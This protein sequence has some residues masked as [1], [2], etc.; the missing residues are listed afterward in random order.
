MKN[1]QSTKPNALAWTLIRLQHQNDGMTQ[2]VP[3]WNPFCKHDS[4]Q[5]HFEFCLLFPIP[6]SWY[7]SDPS[8]LSLQPSSHLN[9]SHNL[10]VFSLTAK[11]DGDLN[12][13]SIFSFLCTN[14]LCQIR[15]ENR[16]LQKVHSC[17]TWFSDKSYQCLNNL[18]VSSYITLNRIISFFFDVNYQNCCLS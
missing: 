12:L 6:C 4:C 9:P 3:R 10:F 11:Q 18:I 2:S 15:Q 7:S 1:V 8:P 5:S 16:I 17:K 14:L 13:K